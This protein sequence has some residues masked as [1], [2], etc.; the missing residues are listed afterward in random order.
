MDTQK[1]CPSGWH[2]PGED[3]M[4]KFEIVCDTTKYNQHHFQD[5]LLLSIFLYICAVHK[6]GSVGDLAQLVRVCDSQSQDKGSTPLI[7]TIIIRCL[8][9][10]NGL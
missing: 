4:E 10:I 5:V 3:D 9:Y 8:L 6:G 7:S 1:I 2:L